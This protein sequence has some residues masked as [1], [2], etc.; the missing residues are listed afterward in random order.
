MTT[1]SVGILLVSIPMDT[2]PVFAAWT[3]GKRGQCG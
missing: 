1:P 3:L 2:Q